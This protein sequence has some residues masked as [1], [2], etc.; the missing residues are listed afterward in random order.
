MASM[1]G[2]PVVQVAQPR[3]RLGDLHER[4]VNFDGWSRRP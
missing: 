4:V 1:T 3:R 2:V